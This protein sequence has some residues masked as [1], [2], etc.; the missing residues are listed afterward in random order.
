MTGDSI[1]QQ[2]AI[3]GLFTRIAGRYDLLNRVLS[4]GQDQ[5]WRREALALAR[6]PRGGG[7]LDVATGT[8]DLALLAL[9]ADPTMHVVG[10]DLTPAMLALARQKS[11]G[12]TLSWAISDGLTLSFPG[13][14]FDAVTSAFMMRNVPDVPRA[15]REQV[16]VVRPGGRVV[17]LEMSWPRRPPMTW[18]FQFYFFGWAPLIGQLLSGDREA[19]AYLPRSVKRFLTPDAMAEE[20]RK[21]G[22]SDVTW[23]VRMGGTVAL[24]VGTKA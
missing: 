15:L 5:R 1:R 2:D 18:L 23:Q 6:V 13:D 12:E 17:C 3:R 24:Y 7:L 21:A 20:M 4:L 9:S 19:Y 10:A 11:T 22:L 16:R 14:T 8:G